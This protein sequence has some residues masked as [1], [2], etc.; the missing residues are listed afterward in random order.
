L[1]ALRAESDEGPVTKAID[2]FR[3]WTPVLA[4]LMGTFTAGCATER[5]YVWFHDLPQAATPTETPVTVIQPRDLIV[6]HVRDQPAMTGEFMVRE[7]GGYLQPT[8]GNV[9]VAGRT[10]A[11]V[12][13]ELTQRMATVLVNPHV[14]VSV[15]RTASVRVNVVG[16]VRTPGAYELTRDRT[17]AAA[18]ASAGW[19]TDFA[20]TDR[21][22]VVRNG[23]HRIRFRAPELTTPESNSARF[24]LRDGDVVVVE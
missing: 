11:Q 6:V 21:I 18:L 23:E 9:V 2:S 1:V 19:L 3:R 24:R 12:G 15:A 22:F 10:P 20:N 7:D 14:T 17:V 5:A 13:A 8:L 16:E 4:V